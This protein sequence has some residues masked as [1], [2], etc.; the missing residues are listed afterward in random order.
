MAFYLDT[1]AAVKLVIHERETAALLRWSVLPG[2]S[3]VSSDLTRTELVR[4]TRRVSPDRIEQVRLLLSSLTLLSLSTDVFERAALLEPDSLRALDAIHLAAAMSLGDDLEAI[5]TYDG[6]LS[7]AA[8]A[9]GVA[10]IAPG[11]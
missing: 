7:E 9:N 2:R 10:V 4:A 11:A 8:A 3:I 1:S 6:R 5:V